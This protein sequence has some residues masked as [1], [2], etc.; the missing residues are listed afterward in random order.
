M[1]FVHDLSSAVRSLRKNIGF[2]A[3]IVGMLA[4]G[5]GATTAM[6]SVADGVLFAPLPYTN[7]ARLFSIVNHGTRVGDNISALDLLDL[8]RNA[9]ALDEA[10]CG[11]RTSTSPSR[12]TAHRSGLAPEMSRRTGSRCSAS[13]PNSAAYSQKVKTSPGPPTL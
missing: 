5:I 1:T 4:V 2:A 6:F 11:L 12:A 9:T 13:K 8:R 10:R 3:A 7:E